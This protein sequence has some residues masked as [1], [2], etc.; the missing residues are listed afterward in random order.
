MLA[1]LAAPLGE[2]LR[3]HARPSELLPAGSEPDQ[4]GLLLFDADGE[5][6]SVND[7]A[8]DWLA[9]LPAEPGVA[10]EHGLLPV[11]LLITVFRAARSATGPAT[12]RRARA[13]GRVTVDGSPVTPRVYGKPTAATG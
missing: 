3:N 6:V 4:P 11:W 8:Q 2:A 7:E 5:I 10:T 1:R 9:R 12:A 13:S